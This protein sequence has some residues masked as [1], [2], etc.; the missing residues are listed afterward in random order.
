[1]TRTSGLITS[2][3]LICLQA[4][5][6]AQPPAVS[7][8]ETFESLWETFD[9]R[10]ALFQAKSIDWQALHDIYRPQVTAA[11]TDEELFGILTGMLSHL[12]DNHVILQASSL[13]RLFGAGYLGDYLAE[14]GLAGAMQF[15]QQHPLSVHRF[16]SPP[17]TVGNG[18]FQF[19]WVDEGIG[20]PHFFGFEDLEG[21][22]AAV[23]AVLEE[24]A[25]ARALI[26]DVRYNAGG[27]DR[28]GQTIANRFADQKRLYMVTRDRSGPDHDDF[29]AC[30]RSGVRRFGEGL[31]LVRRGAGGLGSAH[32]VR[33]GR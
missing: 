20:Y 23:D 21:S 26:V 12:N 1:M 8:E 25:G 33:A 14:M 5:A 30:S 15:L 7:P 4:A 3:L 28:V 22:A 31:P 9:Q 13:D 16:R 19:G 6:L 17:Q 24:L 2:L 18:I 11:T 10:Y 29:A 27:E 32:V